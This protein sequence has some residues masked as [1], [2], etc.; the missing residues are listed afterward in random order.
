M[1]D[2]RFEKS[3]LTVVI[4]AFNEADRIG[5]GLRT[6]GALA[7]SDFFRLLRLEEV[8]VVDDGSSDATHTVTQAYS[9]SLP[10]LR[11][12]RN[13]SNQGKGFSI[14][15]GVLEA[16]GDWILIADAD[17]ATPWEEVDKLFSVALAKHTSIVIG[18]R[19]VV[20][21]QIVKSQSWVRENIGK[22]FSIITR[23]IFPLPFR[24]TQCG[25]KLIRR[26]QTQSLFGQLRVKGFAWD[27]EFLLLSKYAGLLIEEV[28]VVWCHIEESRVH[29][30]RHGFQMLLDI[31]RLRIA[32]WAR[33]IPVLR[34]LYSR[35]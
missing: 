28:A 5:I 17:M 12:L 13:H 35:P 9:H 32:G 3:P 27:V 33:T 19:D 4:P 15:R 16:R 2:A 21:S 22:L 23:L 30:F 24:D 25:F 14:R 10:N 34:L 1:S 11:V 6:L 7:T 29:L 31:L 20:G 18:S 26:S 8:I